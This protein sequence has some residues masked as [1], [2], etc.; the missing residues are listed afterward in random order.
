MFRNAED[1]YKDSLFLDYEDC[2]SEVSSDCEITLCKIPD[3][4][5]AEIDDEVHYQRVKSYIYPQLKEHLKH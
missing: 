3:L 1:T 5:W 4:I 2:L